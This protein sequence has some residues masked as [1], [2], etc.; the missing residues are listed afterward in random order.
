VSISTGRESDRVKKSP[1][2][3]LEVYLDAL[4]SDPDAP[5]PAGLDRDMAQFART[6]ALSQQQAIQ[7]RSWKNALAT[8]QA[9]RMNQDENG[10]LSEDLPPIRGT[11]LTTRRN[12]KTNRFSFLLAV[13]ALT[14]LACGLFVFLR[15]SNSA[16]T[17]HIVALQQTATAAIS[18]APIYQSDPPPNSTINIQI[19]RGGDLGF[20]RLQISDTGG[21]PLSISAPELAPSPVNAIKV[22]PDTSL[23]IDPATDAANG[24]QVT[25]TCT[26]SVMAA[27]P[28]INTTLSYSTNDPRQASVSYHV[29]CINLNLVSPTATPPSAIATPAPT[30]TPAIHFIPVTPSSAIETPASAQKIT[31]DNAQH[32]RVDGIPGKG[33]LYQIAWSPDRT[34]V[35]I[36][37]TT[38]VWLYKSNALNGS[39]QR[40]QGY[41]G[42]MTQVLF[43]PKGDLIAS[44]ND[45][46]I[47]L[48]DVK[49]V[50]ARSALPGIS[51]GHVLAFSPNETILAAANGS[52]IELWNVTPGSKRSSWQDIATKTSP[53]NQGS[54]THTEAEVIH[55]LAFSPNGKLLASGDSDNEIRLWDIQ[56][57]AMQGEFVPTLP[58]G[59][60]HAG[61]GILALAFSSDGKLIVSGGGDNYVRIWNVDGRY[62]R[63]S[64]ADEVYGVDEVSFSADGNAVSYRGDSAWFWQFESGKDPAFLPKDTW[65]ESLV[66]ASD[67]SPLALGIKDD[68]WVQWAPK[69]TQQKGL[70]GGY[71]LGPGCCDEGV[72]IDLNVDGTRLSARGY[73]KYELLNV[74]TGQQQNICKA[75]YCGGSVALSPDGQHMV[76]W[77]DSL[78]GLGGTKLG[79]WDVDTGQVQDL[80]VPDTMTLGV[81]VGVV[82]SPDGKRMATIGA[83]GY[84]GDS[85][86]HELILWDTQ[87]AKPVGALMQ[88]QIGA[89]VRWMN[90]SA[91]SKQLFYVSQSG[92]TIWDVS[93]ARV[94]KT[95]PLTRLSVPVTSNNPYEGVCGLQLSPDNKLVAYTIYPSGAVQPVVTIIDVP[96]GKVSK[97]LM[98]AAMPDPSN[99]PPV[100]LNLCKFAFS[101]DGQTLAAT[102]ANTIQLWQVSTGQLTVLKPS[103]EAIGG[104]AFSPDGK[105]LAS[106]YALFHYAKP[107]QADN[108]I[109]LWDVATG[110]PVAA[111]EG[112]SAQVSSVQF[113]HDGTTLAS[114]DGDGVIYLWR[115]TN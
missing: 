76:V 70:L 105:L 51:G 18:P 56:S 34:L 4:S 50:S 14:I 12:F 73:E 35:A 81:N 16:A 54:V 69:P 65:W 42:A 25:L 10:G 75:Q 28:A 33:S 30:A 92:I 39:G 99:F 62:E 36:A 5:V 60:Y 80:Q 113:S 23:V 106:T 29:E 112:H 102:Y 19:P 41:P 67:G 82:F 48:W 24:T 22:S 96:S 47:V 66:F 115:V 32:L 61:N 93:N 58:N 68:Q 72:D 15:H 57:G 109:H 84:N 7:S 87:S 111:L 40:L 9:L 63:T 37:S 107:T 71:G 13:A 108:A 38:G 2:E 91:D 74:A 79:L 86:F 3:L 89:L 95:I 64:R 43:S 49:T 46:D 6:L 114:A 103:D 98:P 100:Q 97:T 52:T 44:S 90:F 1:E 88:K 78:Y 26:G 27:N 83:D 55:S 77:E 59:L 20:A 21:M 101:P 17:E 110:K 104:I 8:A 53:P 85:D 94:L 31:P 11:P 45:T